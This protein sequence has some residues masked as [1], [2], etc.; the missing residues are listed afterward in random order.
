[1]P[2][3]SLWLSLRQELRCRPLQLWH[4]SALRGGKVLHVLTVLGTVLY[5]SL[6]TPWCELLN[7]TINLPPELCFHS[8]DGAVQLHI[9]IFSTSYSS[10]CG[11]IRDP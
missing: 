8:K 2:S 7:T 4:K 3:S 6:D 10:R 1:M 9:T 11:V 5:P